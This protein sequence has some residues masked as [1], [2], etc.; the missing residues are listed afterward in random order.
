MTP[1]EKTLFGIDKLNVARSTIP[2]VTHVDYSAR[3]QLHRATSGLSRS[4]QPLPWLRLSGGDQHQLQRGSEPIV[5][6]DA[7]DVHGN[8]PRP[9]NR[10]EFGASKGRPGS[11]LGSLTKTSLS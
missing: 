4:H 7:L 10:R 9:A 5:C 1:E 2:A 6:R 11:K 3:V 8:R